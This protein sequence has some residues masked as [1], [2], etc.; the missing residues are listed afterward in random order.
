MANKPKTF[1][2]LIAASIAVFSALASSCTTLSTNN[3]PSSG[4]FGPTGFSSGGG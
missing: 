4:S 1:V 2:I 3:P